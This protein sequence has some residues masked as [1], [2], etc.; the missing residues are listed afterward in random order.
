QKGPLWWSGH[1]R[2][3]HIHCVNYTDLHSPTNGIFQSHVGW[4]FEYRSDHVDPK[5]TKDCVKYPDLV[6]IDKYAHVSFDLYL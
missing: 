2:Y 1:H 5:F 4:V 6:W 3:H